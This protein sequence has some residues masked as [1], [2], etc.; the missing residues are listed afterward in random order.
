VKYVM[1]EQKKVTEGLS[2]MQTLSLGKLKWR[3]S[4]AV[5]WGAACCRI[6]GVI[7]FV[8]NK[9]MFNC[10]GLA[11]KFWSSLAPCLS[12]MVD[13]SRHKNLCC[14]LVKFMNLFLANGIKCRN[15]IILFNS[16]KQKENQCFLFLFPSSL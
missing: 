12:A 4:K 10:A 3:G 7:P 1:E 6:Q 9:F 15:L 8:R 14:L 16:G 5:R 2:N 13:R 11:T